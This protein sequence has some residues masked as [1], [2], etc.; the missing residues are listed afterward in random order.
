MA[1]V[2]GHGM[3]WVAVTERGGLLVC[4][5]NSN[6]QLGLGSRDDADTPT[7]LGG[8]GLVEGDEVAEL[9]GGMQALALLAGDAP[10]DPPAALAHPV[11][12]KIAM[13]AAG[14]QHTMCVTDTGAVWAW[15]ENSLGALGI[16][17]PQTPQHLQRSE[18]PVRWA[19]GL[20]N[21][22][23]A[24]MVACGA[25]HSLV[26]TRTGEVW[27]CGR[28]HLGQTG[29]LH[30]PDIVPTPERVAGLSAVVL[31]AAGYGF[32]GA[33][34]KDGRVWMW[35]A[36]DAGQLGFPPVAPQLPGNAV[37]TQLGPAAFGREAVVQLSL[38]YYQAAAVTATGGLWVWGANSHGELGLGDTAERAVPTLVAAGG[39][40]AW[41][42]SR[43]LMVSCSCNYQL[44]LTVDGGVWTC[45]LN[46][47]GLL[48]H[49]GFQGVWVPTRIV[50]AAFG[51][52]TIVFVAAGYA[53]ASAVTAE[54]LLYSWGLSSTAAMVGLQTTPRP[55]A[56]SLVPGLRIGRACGIRRWHALVF[57][58]GL[59]ARLGAQATNRVLGTDT[60]G[61]VVERGVRLDGDLARMGEGLLR[62]LAVRERRD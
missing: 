13:V 17:D 56:A 40:P 57:C 43:V 2:A 53:Y 29:S 46:D 59:D 33:L 32:S 7:A 47:S 4:G 42:G 20:C 1:M 54:G 27:A 35:G 22:V 28:G 60:A 34:D 37:P 3:F 36:C 61:A 31:V 55:V 9:A 25:N 38:G 18:V 51:G 50:P 30:L 11:E 5:Y 12:C 10:E 8:L 14:L 58:M 45:G 24:R 49:G 39:A 6:G 44:V 52:A 41:G 16:A 48:G 21:G 26:L 15:G 23:P 62:Q 19:P